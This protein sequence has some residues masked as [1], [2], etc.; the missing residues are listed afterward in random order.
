MPEQIGFTPEQLRAFDRDGYIVIRDVVP[1]EV[2][3]DVNAAIDRMFAED[4]PP[5]GA[6]GQ[7][8]Y[9]ISGLRGMPEGN[10][11]G[12]SIDGRGMQRRDASVSGATATA[13]RSELT[14]V[15]LETP[16]LKLAKALV[17]VPSI[18]V[19]WNMSQIAMS[20]PGFSH[21]PGAGHIDG[22]QINEDGYPGTF[23]LLVGVLL[24]DQTTE[25]SGN[26]WVWP[27]THHMHAEYFRAA[28]PEALLECESTPPIKLPEPVQICGKAGDV[29]FAHYLLSHNSGGN[30]E[31]SDIRRC[32]YYR[33]RRLGH[34]EHWRDAVRDARLEF[35]GVPAY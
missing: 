32:A 11:D 16:T 23:T 27:G 4:G 18:E 34:A 3:A 28:G 2:L 35:D 30:Y 12:I 10:P 33:L 24:T 21:R 14:R 19:G 31:S 26:L 15:L 5:E 9:W 17:G 13:V 29:V 25:N 20:L 1:S 22:C 8:Y 6:I 7:W